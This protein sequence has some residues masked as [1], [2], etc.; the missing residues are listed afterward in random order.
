MERRELIFQIENLGRAAH[1]EKFLL[2]AVVLHALAGAMERNI[3]LNLAERANE[4]VELVRS[5]V[6]VINEVQ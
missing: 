3:E 4:F 5:G 1:K 6:I 2:A